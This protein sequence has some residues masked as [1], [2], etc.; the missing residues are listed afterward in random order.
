V[1]ATRNSISLVRHPLVL[2]RSICCALP[3]MAA[4]V[5]ASSVSRL[6][7]PGR[8]IASARSARGDSDTAGCLGG[9]QSVSAS[10]SSVRS[11]PSMS[12]LGPRGLFRCTRSRPVQVLRRSMCILSSP[13]VS[14]DVR[15]LS[16]WS[17][18]R[19]ARRRP[20]GGSRQLQR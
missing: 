6:R 5:K 12:W 7:G 1:R 14:R 16:R 17:R 9:F 8:D 18:R 13:C 19:F 11:H 20:F 4:I 3:R 10:G 2:R 15:C